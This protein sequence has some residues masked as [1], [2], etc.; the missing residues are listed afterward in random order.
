VNYKI[1]P[2]GTIGF[3]YNLSFIRLPQPYSGNDVVAIGP[4]L[5]LAF[6]KKL[7]FKSN[8]QYTSLNTNLNYFFR[9]QYRFKPLSD[10]YLVYT[11]NENM[12]TRTR[13]NQSLIV[14]FVYFM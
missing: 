3:N 11:N 5:D 14:K 13:Q 8:V 9:L 4:Q 12:D 1:Q 6:S 2:F 10:L 7:F